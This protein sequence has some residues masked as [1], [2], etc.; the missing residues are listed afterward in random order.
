MSASPQPQPHYRATAAH[1]IAAERAIRLAHEHGTVEAMQFFT[2]LHPDTQPVVFALMARSAASR[3]GLEAPAG[4]APWWSMAE[5][6]NAHRLFAAGHREKWIEQGH[7]LYI[8]QQRRLT[9]AALNPVDPVT[10]KR[11]R[12][13][14]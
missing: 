3:P 13:L 7:R 9:R 10:D 14:L 12:D 8:A 4:A 2:E 5:L 11:N 1:R 6:R